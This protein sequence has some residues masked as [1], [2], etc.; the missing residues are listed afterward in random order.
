MDKDRIGK[1]IER[2][3]DAL[4]SMGIT[5]EGIILFGSHARGTARPDSDIDL[6]IISPDFS[7]M[8]IR[9]RLEIL[10]LAAGKIM[11]PIGAIGITPD[12]WK[13]GEAPFFA[14]EIAADGVV[15]V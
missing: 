6:V 5:P 2:Y 8:N 13:S 15:V 3:T 9:Q 4:K 1:I 10:G 7:E 14:N 11:E 12:E